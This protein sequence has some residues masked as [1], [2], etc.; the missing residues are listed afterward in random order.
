[1]AWDHHNLVSKVLPI[2]TGSD[3]VIA[4]P[5]QGGRVVNMEMTDSGTLRSIVGPQA[6]AIHKQRRRARNYSLGLFL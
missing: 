2:R 3:V 1:L 4:L 5:D 6:L